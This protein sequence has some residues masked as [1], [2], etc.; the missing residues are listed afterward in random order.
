MCDEARGVIVCGVASGEAEKGAECGWGCCV[1]G[2][3]AEDG[4]WGWRKAQGAEGRDF[5]GE[6]VQGFVSCIV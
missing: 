1:Q 4:W 5:C 2:L 6:W 3:L